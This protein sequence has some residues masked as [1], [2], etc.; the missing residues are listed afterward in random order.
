MFRVDYL[1]QK[2]VRSDQFIPPEH[3][4]PEGWTAAF[5]PLNVLGVPVWGTGEVSQVARKDFLITHLNAFVTTGYGPADYEGNIT[6]T[7]FHNHRNKQLQLS[8]KAMVYSASYGKG[9][10]PYQL[11]VPYL[12]PA[13]DQLTLEVATMMQAP[14]TNNPVPITNL[15]ASGYAAYFTLIGG[16]PRGE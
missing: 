12:V 16:I 13:G 6:L 10:N 2:G 4:L 5:I 11:K 9:G 1:P 3:E 14:S 8:E 15:A 7:I